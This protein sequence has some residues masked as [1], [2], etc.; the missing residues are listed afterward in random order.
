M[1]FLK[2]FIFFIFNSIILLSGCSSIDTNLAINEQI[3]SSEM[4]PD[5]LKRIPVNVVRVVDGDTAVVEIRADYK[6][7]LQKEFGIRVEE[8]VTI[9]FLGI[10]TPESTKEQQLYGVESKEYTTLLLNRDNVEIELDDK[11]VFDKYG[12]LL[13][14]IFA[15]GQSVQQI[16]L[17]EGMARIAYIFDDYKYLDNYKAAQEQAKNSQKNIW[18]IPEYVTDTGFNMDVLTEYM[19]GDEMSIENI[20][21]DEVKT[22]IQSLLD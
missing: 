1:K 17:E 4:V 3:S 16:L 10:D 13:V 18:S 22:F 5:E 11:V 21:L 7:Y 2:L 6:D 14:H 9:R 20:D 8:P 12:R 19:V 15:D